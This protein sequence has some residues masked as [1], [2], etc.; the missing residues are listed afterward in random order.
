MTSNAG[1]FFAACDVRQVLRMMVASSAIKVPKL[2]IG[3]SSSRVWWA[4]LSS[5][6]LERV[7]FAA[8]LL[9][10]TCNAGL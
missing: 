8:Y 6:A 5:A 7:T 4:A 9:L 10:L 1:A 2:C 3:V